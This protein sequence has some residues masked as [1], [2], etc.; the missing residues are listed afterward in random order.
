MAMG[1]RKQPLYDQLVDLLTDKIDHE[2][3]PGDYLPSER[4][5]S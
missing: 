4:D 1:A 3:R 2:L 5:L